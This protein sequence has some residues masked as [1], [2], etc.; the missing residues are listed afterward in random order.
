MRILRLRPERDCKV[1]REVQ[2]YSKTEFSEWIRDNGPSSLDSRDAVDIE[3]IDFVLFSYLTGEIMTLE[4]KERGALPRMAQK[5][6]QNVLRQLLQLSSPATVQ[7][8]R[9]VRKINYRGH[10]LIQLQNTTPDNG[11]VKLDGRKVSRNELL[12]F[13]NFDRE[14]KRFDGHQHP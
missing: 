10:H 3:D 11:W 12:L 7:T 5:D 13:I 4:V 8:I 14:I 6:T 1:V 9:G 2:V